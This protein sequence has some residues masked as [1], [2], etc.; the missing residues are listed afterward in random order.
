[1]KTKVKKGEVR[2]LKT[3]YICFAIRLELI[4][5]LSVHDDQVT[6][7]DILKPAGPRVPPQNLVRG[8]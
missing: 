3:N 5:Y 7:N 4:T 1:M 6:S 8:Q 2:A